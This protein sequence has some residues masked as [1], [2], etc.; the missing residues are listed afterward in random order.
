MT[1]PTLSIDDLFK[2]YNDGRRA[3]LAGEPYPP[4]GVTT[5]EKEFRRGYAMTSKHAPRKA[6]DKGSK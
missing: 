4:K 1:E 3:F 2:A 5:L 6:A